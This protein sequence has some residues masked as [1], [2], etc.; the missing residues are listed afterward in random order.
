MGFKNNM[1]FF[2]ETGLKC[3]STIILEPSEPITSFL[4]WTIFVISKICGLIFDFGVNFSNQGKNNMVSYSYKWPN[5]C[6]YM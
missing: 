3:Y 4:G 5:A 1:Q 2:D 6:H